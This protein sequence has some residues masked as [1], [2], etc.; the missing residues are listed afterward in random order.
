[1][2]FNQFFSYIFSCLFSN[3]NAKSRNFSCGRF[4]SFPKKSAS[5]SSLE[6]WGS[7]PSLQAGRLRL[8]PK[9]ASDAS[10][11]PVHHPPD[12][13]VS[14]VILG[15]L[16]ISLPGFSPD[17][18]HPDTRSSQIT[19]WLYLVMTFSYRHSSERA[20]TTRICSHPMMGTC[21]IVEKKTTQ[22]PSQSDVKTPHHLGKN[23]EKSDDHR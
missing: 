22:M 15:Q 8:V 19:Q 2:V 9:L 20:I 14:I 23:M 3:R 12:S 17:R 18:H 4:L 13:I 10:V 6:Q 7:N 5:W 1:M 16:Y 21:R 11:N